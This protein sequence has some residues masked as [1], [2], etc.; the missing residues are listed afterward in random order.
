[1]GLRLRPRIVVRTASPNR[2][3]R[4]ADIS[5]IVLHSTEGKN[6][7][8][9]TAD[10]KGLG[11]WFSNPAAQ[12]SCHVA[13]DGDGQSARYVADEDKAWHCAG[14]NSASLGIEQVGFAADSRTAWLARRPQLRETARWI[15][16]WSRTHKIPIRKGAVSNGV[17]TRSGVLRHSDLGPMG[18]GH[19]D[20]GS[21]YPFGLV[22]LT[23]RYYAL[24]W[25]R[26]YK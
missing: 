16:S 13:T 18:G 6:Y 17:V 10:L 3:K 19:H 24:R 8:K 21:G 2:S 7:P 26:R 4:S 23:A 12:V 14:Y 11:A 1:M 20:P 15:A 25:S 9:S 22:L 5:L